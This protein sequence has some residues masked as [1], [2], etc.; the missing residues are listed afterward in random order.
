MKKVLC[1]LMSLL[2]FVVPALASEID[3]SGYSVEELTQIRDE[4]DAALFEKDGLILAEVGTYIVGIDIGAGSY[5]LKPYPVD[6]GKLGV[7]NYII[8][9]NDTA[10]AEYE[11][12]RNAYDIAYR[13]ARAAEK[14][15]ET[16][17]WPDLVNESQYIT[18]SGKLYSKRNESGKITLQDGQ[19]L[20]FSSSWGAITI[21][22]KKA[23]GLFME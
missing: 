16:P 22:I 10:H 14:A 5:I 7:L 2:L 1:V 21:S 12:A 19:I 3:F 17:V 9:K 13:N 8:Y 11:K 20:V 4:I 18:E 15:A 23:P 6:E